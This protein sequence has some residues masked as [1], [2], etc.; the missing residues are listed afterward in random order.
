MRSQV[1]ELGE[2][3]AGGTDL[4]VRMKQ[5]LKR[6]SFL[7]TLKNLKEL[8]GVKLAEGELAIGAKTSLRDVIRSP[9]VQ[10][11]AKGLGEAL[12]SVGAYTIQHVRGTIGGNLCQ[13]TRCLYYNQSAFWRSG[14]AP[15]HKAG[16]K[17]C[18]ARE[19]SDRC[20]ST[21]QSDG[22]TA[23]LALDAKV[24]LQSLRGERTIPVSDL[25]TMKGETPL[26]I[27]SDEILTTIRIPIPS[28]SAASAYERI[29]YRSA[30]DFPVA[31][32]AVLIQAEDKAVKRARIAVGAMGNGPL[33][34]IQ[35]AELL[36]GRSLED[37][38]AMVRAARIA[39]D[40]ASAFAVDNVGAT[41][42]WR[43]SMV[44]VLVRRALRRACEAAK[45]TGE[46][47]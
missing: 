22:A 15:C 4:L 7:I 10:R 23:L 46:G 3:L 45:G 20:R 40:H 6:P 18:Y 21:N 11:Y 44:E 9:W 38:E 26:D 27:R 8:E 25:F 42:E 37:E 12:S 19:G 47:S 34:M 24:T 33:L 32:A 5:R 30:I 43:V 28:E 35:A 29:S 31:C 16:G 1:G 17:I 2:I 36:E 39:M 41:V 14:K 13:D